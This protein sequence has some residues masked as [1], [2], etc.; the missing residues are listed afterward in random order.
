MEVRLWSRDMLH[1]VGLYIVSDQR[2]EVTIGI[3]DQIN[4]IRLG[5]VLRKLRGPG[6]SLV[7]LLG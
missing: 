5:G 2:F 1:R 6:N 4:Q 7:I 3:R